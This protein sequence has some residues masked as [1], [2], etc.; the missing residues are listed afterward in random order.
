MTLLADL[1]HIT[2]P[3]LEKPFPSPQAGI[4]GAESHTRD[5]VCN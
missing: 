4:V 1:G 5:Y 2:G 3:G